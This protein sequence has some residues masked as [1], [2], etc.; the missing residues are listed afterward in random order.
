MIPGRKLSIVVAVALLAIGLAACGGGDD[1]SSSTTE[2]TSQDRLQA[3]SRDDGGSTGKAR[4]D[5][6]GGEAGSG[7][8][9]GESSGS[10]GG[11]PD[12][13]V[14]KEHNDSGGGSSQYRVKGGDNSVQ[15]FGAEADTSERDDAAVA[16]H[17]FLDARAAEDWKSAC[18]FLS[19][20]V[21]Q[22]L[23]S[24]AVKAQ[25][26]AAKQGSAEQFDATSCASILSRM[27]NRAALP[28]LRKEAA[29]A[30]IGSLRIEGDRAFVIYRGIG[31]TIIAI[32]VTNEGGSWKVS[33][34]AGTP[35]N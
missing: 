35:L 24:F 25:E 31:G 22:S 20:E 6:E 29:Q 19:A 32:P 7:G 21:R 33:G 15:E 17:N 5:D 30:D 27:T 14:P 34:L 16:L 18:S 10:G 23:E 1:S 2:A 8:G 3:K 13:F 11:T 26:A 4:K 9:E 28:E 12:S